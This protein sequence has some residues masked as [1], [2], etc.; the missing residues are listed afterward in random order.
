MRRQRRITVNVNSAKLA[1]TQTQVFIERKVK[2]PQK[3]DNLQP[4]RSSLRRDV[5]FS[6]TEGQIWNKVQWKLWRSKRRINLYSAEQ[7]SI[8]EV[9]PREDP[10]RVV[11]A[12]FYCAHHCQCALSYSSNSPK[13]EAEKVKNSRNRMSGA[14]AHPCKLLY[15]GYLPPTGI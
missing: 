15:H 10:E 9:E 3:A 11:C 8:A 12:G 7:E 13:I 4:S 2:A 1:W 6:Q 14:K 5:T